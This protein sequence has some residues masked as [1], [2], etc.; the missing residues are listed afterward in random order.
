[1][2]T[3]LGNVQQL[4]VL[5]DYSRMARGLVGQ[6]P[7]KDIINRLKEEIAIA[8]GL[9][10]TARERQGKLLDALRLIES[11][12]SILAAAELVRGL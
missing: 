10:Q 12:T 6:Q 11:D 2:D 4:G 1:M 3:V 8:E 9:E 7:P 5:G